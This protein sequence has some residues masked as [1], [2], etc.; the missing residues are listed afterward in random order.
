MRES[1]LAQYPVLVV[2]HLDL[3]T[4]I[5]AASFARTLAAYRSSGGIV[6]RDSAS[7][8]AIATALRAAHREPL[9]TGIPGG[10]FLSTP[11]ERLDGFLIVS[12]FTDE[13]LEIDHGSVTG[14]SGRRFVLPPFTV[15][16]HDAIVV[17]VGLRLHAYA[18]GFDPSDRLTMWACKVEGVDLDFHGGLA[19]SGRDACSTF[20]EHAGGP[21]LRYLEYIDAFASA[22]IAPSPSGPSVGHLHVDYRIPTPAP[23]IRVRNDVDLPAP[24][25]EPVAAGNVAAYARDVYRDGSTSD[26]LDNGLVRLIVSPQAGGRAFSFVDDITG[27][28]VFTTVGALRDDVAIEP[29]LSTV[30]KIAKYTHDFPAGTFNRTYS[31]VLSTSERG[32]SVALA[33]A[34]PDVVPSGARFEKTVTLEPRARAFELSESV[35]FN[36]P[37]SGQRAVSVSSLAVDNPGP[38][39]VQRVY[40]PSAITFAPNLPYHVPYGNAIGY[41]AF[42]A[43]FRKSDLATIAW[44]AGDIEDATIVIKPYSVIVRLTLARGKTAHVRYGLESASNEDDAKKLVAKADADAQRNP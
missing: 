27:D 6:V 28:N 2:P 44:R 5:F 33:Y 17:P 4:P 18:D 7:A 1:D 21:P 11:S 10:R 34:A 13:P 26:V 40:A 42:L 43:P 3:K 36:G 14:E 38:D 20:I 29:P 9:V 23:G 30:D 41:Y 39:S 15:A 22:T 25:F 31:D 24:T 19:L 37:A 12:N 32:A 16:Q 8:D 35:S